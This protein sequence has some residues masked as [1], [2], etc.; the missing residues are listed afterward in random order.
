MKEFIAG[1]VLL[2][3]ITLAIW[4]VQNYFLP[5]PFSVL[6]VWGLVALFVMFKGL[7]DEQKTKNI[8]N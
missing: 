5:N 1:L 3:I 8:E 4:F 2:F 7:E 6:E